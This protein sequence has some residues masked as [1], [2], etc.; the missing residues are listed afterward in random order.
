[1]SDHDELIKIQTKLDILIKHFENHLS[2]HFKERMVVW[3][4]VLAALV[5]LIIK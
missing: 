4:I 5:G 3:A 2:H 1:M